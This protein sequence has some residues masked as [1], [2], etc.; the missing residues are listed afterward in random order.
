MNIHPKKIKELVLASLTAN[1]L[2]PKKIEEIAGYLER[3]NLKLYIR[4][5]KNWQRQRNVIVT[6]PKLA[7]KESQNNLKKIFPDKQIINEIDPS[8]LIGINII[9]CDLV[10]NL[11][12][13]NQLEDI[14]SYSTE[15]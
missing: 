14:V 15:L 4:A 7:D 1:S 9:D 6:L 10:Y 5:L 2:D 11:S 8:L 3:K 12:L 13:K